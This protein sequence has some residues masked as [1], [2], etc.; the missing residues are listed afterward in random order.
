[1]GQGKN[2]ELKEDPYGTFRYSRIEVGFVVPAIQKIFLNNQAGDSQAASNFMR[3]LPLSLSLKL[4]QFEIRRACG[5]K[6]L[7]SFK[8]T[9][10]KAI[11]IDFRRTLDNI[12]DIHKR[13]DLLSTLAIEGTR[14][15]SL[16]VANRFIEVVR[17]KA[18]EWH[19]PS[20]IDNDLT[21]RFER[22]WFPPN[23]AHCRINQSFPGGLT[24]ALHPASVDISNRI[25]ETL[26]SDESAPLELEML[27]SSRRH[28]RVGHFR[29]SFLDAWSTAEICI[30]R[31]SR[32]LLERNNAPLSAIEE[33]LR[34][35]FDQVLKERV[36]EKT[37]TCFAKQFANDWTTLLRL[38][39][40]RDGMMHRGVSQ[41]KEDDLDEMIQLADRMTQVGI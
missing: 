8:S 11:A 6:D 20:A 31:W 29:A 18:G 30:Y 3:S 37:G 27:W 34:G 1:M 7:W 9:S 10:Q 14:E 35:R 5:K 26:R 15:L 40:K 24:L 39:K 2:V 13:H 23:Y 17:W 41:V 38:K 32:V 12:S 36:E 4:G 19:L 28:K 33:I 21:N 22:L 25:Q 16:Q